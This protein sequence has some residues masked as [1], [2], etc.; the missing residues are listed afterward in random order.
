MA[1]KKKNGFVI[2]PE[3]RDL[4]METLAA[5]VTERVE[6]IKDK[7]VA[8]LQE[9]VRLMDTLNSFKE[10]LSAS[11]KSPVEKS[12]DVLRFTV[13]PEFMDGQDIRSITFDGIG[14]VNVMDD[15]QVSTLDKERLKEWL[16][17]EDLSDLIVPTVNAQTLAAALRKRLK[18]GKVMPPEDVVKVTPITRAQITRSV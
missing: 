18:D 14:R 17:E 2:S 12:Y 15:I 10:N 9:A 6:Y 11:I 4:A 8:D 13:I 1:T 7:K 5:Y 3:Q 16:D